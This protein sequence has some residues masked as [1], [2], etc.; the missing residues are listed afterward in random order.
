MIHPEDSSGTRGPISS[1][2][3][4]KADK[5]QIVGLERTSDLLGRCLPT[6]LDIKCCDAELDR[7]LLRPYLLGKG[8][9]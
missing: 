8:S 2:C 4:G 7:I 3:L 6:D 5:V 1:R 9:D